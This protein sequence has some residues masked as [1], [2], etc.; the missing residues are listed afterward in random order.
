MN[1]SNTNLLLKL[2][3]IFN[4]VATETRLLTTPSFA[5]TI[6]RTLMIFALCGF[7]ALYFIV[8]GEITVKLLKLLG[9]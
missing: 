4:E 9:I 5:E 2:K 3:K 8:V 1:E 6:Y 7:L